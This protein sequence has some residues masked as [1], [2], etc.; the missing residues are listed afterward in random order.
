MQL[1]YLNTGV[2][3]YVTHL[4]ATARY[5]KI[6]PTHHHLPYSATCY[7]VFMPCGGEVGP[8]R[9]L[10]VKPPTAAPLR[11][12][13]LEISKTDGIFYMNKV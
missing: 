9:Y 7:G 1:F 2:S 6:T 12:L 8:A 11:R 13:H 3:F 5:L 10:Y 4:F